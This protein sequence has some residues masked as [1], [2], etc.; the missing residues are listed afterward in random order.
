MGLIQTNNS[1]YFHLFSSIDKIATIFANEKFNASCH[2]NCN[3]KI[4][5]E[6]IWI[7]M[8]FQL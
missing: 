8:R 4:I 7:L 3:R 1:K 6:I 5:A 2:V